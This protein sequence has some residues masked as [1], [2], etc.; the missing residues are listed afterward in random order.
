MA[1]LSSDNLRKAS[2]K[3]GRG[4][5][6]PDAIRRAIEQTFLALVEE[7][8]TGRETSAAAV[9]RRITDDYP[10][11][12][13]SLPSWQSIN[14]IVKPLRDQL[15]V[16]NSLDVNWSLSLWMKEPHGISEDDLPIILKVQK[17]M[18]LD[19]EERLARG[20]RDNRLT[21]REARWAG[22]VY[23]V[24]AASG[25]TDLGESVRSPG[26]DTLVRFVQNY[27][28]RERALELMEQSADSYDIDLVLAMQGADSSIGPPENPFKLF[29]QVMLYQELGLLPVILKKEN[30][31]KL[32]E[33][34]RFVDTSDMSEG[35]SFAFGSFTEDFM[36]KGFAMIQQVFHTMLKKGISIEV[37]F[38]TE[39]WRN[40]NLFEFD[41]NYPLFQTSGQYVV[42]LELMQPVWNLIKHDGKI[43]PDDPNPV[44]AATAF[45]KKVVVRILEL[46]KD[47]QI[48]EQLQVRGEANQ[49]DPASG[50]SIA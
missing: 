12:A 24:L 18:A 28:R 8:K 37:E 15:T 17:L 38:S 4:R 31:Q 23:R 22:P 33:M 30:G 9:E 49:H 5:R 40:F 27:A 34:E 41:E 1:N 48:Q 29:K 39:D 13:E 35:T 21:V 26:A 46:L 45:W 43:V 32:Q 19:S 10:D 2:E 11:M 16:G 3:D 47:P 42:D 20:F 14:K 44:K 7:G 6:V 50:G 25:L 36:L